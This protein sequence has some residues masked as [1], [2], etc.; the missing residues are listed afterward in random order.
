M[1][2]RTSSLGRIDKKADT[3]ENQ[4]RE[5]I[6]SKGISPGELRQQAPGKKVSDTTQCHECGLPAKKTQTAWP[7]KEFGNKGI[8]AGHHPG[9]G[10][11][12]QETRHKKEIQAFGVEPECAG[13]RIKEE[14]D[15]KNPPRTD[16]I[17]KETGWKRE[18]GY[19]KAG[20]RKHQRGKGTRV[21]NLREGGGDSR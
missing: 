1:P 19:R 21:G 2:G 17:T 6:E 12:K 16:A 13:D 3:R 7:F 10:N 9:H 8:A 20:D 11:A 15:E 5:T 4:Q 14:T 18:D